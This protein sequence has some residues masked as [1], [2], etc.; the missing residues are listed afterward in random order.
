ML[1]E[2]ARV[3]V[4]KLMVLMMICACERRG[5]SAVASMIGDCGWLL[6]GASVGRTDDD[7]AWPMEGAEGVVGAQADLKIGDDS[8]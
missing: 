1:S 8:E 2:R 4:R 6:E 3:S 5:F 7:E